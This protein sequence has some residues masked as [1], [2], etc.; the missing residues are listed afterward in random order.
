MQALGYTDTDILTTPVVDAAGV[1]KYVDSIWNACVPIPQ[2]QHTGAVK[3]TNLL[4]A[5]VHTY[6]EPACAIERVMVDTFVPYIVD[7]KTQTTATVVPVAPPGSGDARV[8]VVA[9]EKGHPLHAEEQAAHK[10][11][12]ALVLGPDH[13]IAKAAFVHQ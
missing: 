6:P 7:A 10:V 3:P 4:A 1:A 8:R 13:P 2:P 12:A 11:G 5:G 9:T